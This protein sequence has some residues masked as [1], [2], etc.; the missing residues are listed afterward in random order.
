MRASCVC[1]WSPLA[2]GFL[3]PGL[4][5]SSLGCVLLPLHVRGQG[6]GDGGGFLTIYPEQAL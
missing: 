2:G 5:A 4:R 3:V 6:F 1:V